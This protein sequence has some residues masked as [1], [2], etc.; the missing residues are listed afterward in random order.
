MIVSL[1]NLCIVGLETCLLHHH[2]QT[3]HACHKLS[4]L[5]ICKT[6]SRQSGNYTWHQSRDY[7][8][9]RGQSSVVLLLIL[10]YRARQQSDDLSRCC[11]YSFLVMAVLLWPLLYTQLFH[12]A[13]SLCEAVVDVH[14]CSWVDGNRQLASVM[15]GLF[16]CST[17]MVGHRQLQMELR[18]VSCMGD[19]GVMDIRVGSALWKN[20]KHMN[21]YVYMR[22]CRCCAVS[23]GLTC[24]HSEGF[25]AA[26]VF[27]LKAQWHI[28]AY[29]SR[30]CRQQWPLMLLLTSLHVFLC[31]CVCRHVWECCCWVCACMC[32][33]CLYCLLFN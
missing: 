15:E 9:G 26:A 16:C 10:D 7:D 17:V 14:C 1:P 18:C 5:I 8:G 19:Q 28:V 11:W 12:P 4:E 3:L 29:C 21:V 13:L 33:M 23:G 25:P 24:S 6:I 20:V 30:Q 2:V 27:S 32:I 22:V 31:S